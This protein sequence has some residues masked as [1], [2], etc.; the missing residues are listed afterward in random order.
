VEVVQGPQQPFSGDPFFDQFFRDFFEGHS[1][2]EYTRNSLGSGV[3]IDGDKGLVLTNEH[4]IAR[5]SQIKVTL[6]DEREFAAK[7]VGSDPESDLAVLELQTKDRL[8]ALTMGDSADL[9]IG[10]TVI[11][12][13]NPFGLSHTV[14]SG[15][16]SAVNRSLKT[17]GRVYMDFIQT[18]ASIN[19]GNS[20]GPLLNLDGELIGI[21]TAIYGGD[22]QGIGFA[23]PINKAKRIVGDLI[24][25]GEVHRAWLGLWIQPLDERLATYLKA[26]PGGGVVIADIEKGGPADG[27]GLAR[28]DLLTHLD[29]KRIQSV[30]EY[31]ELLK[32][33][34]AGDSVTM[35]YLRKGQEQTATLKASTFPPDLADRI[36]WD[37]YGLTV[38]EGG[39]RVG[40]VVVAKVRSGSSAAQIGIKPGDIIHRINE[41]ETENVDQF[42]KALSRYAFRNAIGLVIQRGPRA[43]NITLTP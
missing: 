37:R 20:G 26:P 32:G 23:I 31:E 15:L 6:G 2:R 17:R 42:R 19:P 33:F 25:Y 16:V 28:G 34:K 3:I 4:V 18:D 12:I 7:L 1:P 35:S 40:H 43:Y 38:K 29:K 27:K 13:G 22:A 11:A 14:T 30:D 10:E 9:M 21:N 41:I 8:P 39:G 36:G 5:A 24:S